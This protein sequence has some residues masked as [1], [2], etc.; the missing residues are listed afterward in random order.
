MPGRAPE[1]SRK[2][3]CGVLEMLKEDIGGCMV[4]PHGRE[5]MSGSEGG[6][7]LGQWAP[8]EPWFGVGLMSMDS[9]QKTRLWLAPAM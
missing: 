2:E 8:T 6:G 1:L 7:G 4:S 5:K 9:A 3:G